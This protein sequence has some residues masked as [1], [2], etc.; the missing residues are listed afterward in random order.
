MKTNE[1]LI[2]LS[3]PIGS[4]DSYRHNDLIVVNGKK[5]SQILKTLRKTLDENII[6][7]LKFYMAKLH[8][9]DKGAYGTEIELIFEAVKNNNRILVTT[10]IISFN[11]FRAEVYNKR[12]LMSPN[13]QSWIIDSMCYFDHHYL[14]EDEICHSLGYTEHS[15]RNELLDYMGLTE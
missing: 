5:P 10:G 6:Q 8:C 9:P 2:Y 3:N 7:S 4:Y 14:H 11:T 13:F 1:C 15:Y 12:A